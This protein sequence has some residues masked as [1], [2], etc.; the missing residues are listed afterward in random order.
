MKIQ[1]DPH[2][3]MFDQNMDTDSGA[4][5]GVILTPVV[6]VNLQSICLPT[7]ALVPVAG[8][9]VPVA[10]DIPP[11]TVP[12]PVVV[13]R[14]VNYLHHLMGHANLDSIQRTSTYYG[15]KCVGDM[16]PCA[17]CALAKI[18]QNLV[19]K[20][21]SSRGNSPGYRLFVDISCSLDPSYGVS[22][23]WVLIVDDFSRFHW[24]YFLRAKSWCSYGCLPSTVK[25][26]PPD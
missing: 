18:K 1:K 14:N 13:R 8:D 17:Y 2:S 6:N 3:I 19:P 4:I 23:Y 15:T 10:C 25:D 20:T 9:P 5:T 12:T 22:R 26:S 7:A 16:T 11:A 21:T 24:S